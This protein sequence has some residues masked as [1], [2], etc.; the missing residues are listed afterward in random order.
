MPPR[1]PMRSILILLAVS[2]AYGAGLSATPPVVNW[3]YTPGSH[4]YP[5]QSISLTSSTGATSYTAAAVSENGWLLVNSAYLAS[6][7]VSSG[8]YL[9]V[10]NAADRLDNGSYQGTVNLTDD[11]ATP[12]PSRSI[13]R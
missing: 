11:Q 13:S 5:A 7:S 9:T 2:T 10:S 12:P 8:V 1:N 3:S 6:S 4:T